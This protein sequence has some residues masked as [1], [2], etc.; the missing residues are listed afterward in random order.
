MVLKVVIALV[1]LGHGIGH[2]IGLLQV[3]KMATINPSFHGDSWILTGVVGTTL[4]QIVGVV[5]WVIAMAGFA[6]LAAVVMG[7][8]P[9]AWWSPLAIASAVVSLVGIVLFPTAFPPFSTL[10]A[11]AVDVAVIVA[12]LWSHW[13]PVDLAA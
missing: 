2:S 11:L 3:F 9:M 8:L 4:T 7:W 6:A 5:L 12:V 1:L 13:S 10:G